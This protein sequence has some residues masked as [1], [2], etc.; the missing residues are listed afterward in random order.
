[1]TSKNPAAIRYGNRDAE[2]KFG[3]IHS[4]NKLAAFIV[5]SGREPNHYISMESE[6]KP[7]RKNGTICRSTGAFQIKAG[8]SVKSGG[9]EENIG[10]YIEAVDGDIV[11]NAKNGR[12]RIIG[13]NIDLVARGADGQNGNVVIDAN[14]K[15]IVNAPIVTISS[16]VSTRVIS[17][18]TVEMIGKAILNCYG[19]IM[20]FADGATKIVGSKGG[21]LV[22]ERN[23]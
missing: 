16:K 7:H 12:I 9:L 17:D 23:R 2:I 4:D 3:H 8:D 1:M 14:E 10:V 15:V 22:E 19:G 6:G 13:E 21:S 11:L 20:D 18:Q 5:R